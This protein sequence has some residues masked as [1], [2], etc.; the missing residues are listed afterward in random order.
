MASNS[1]IMHPLG[2]SIATVDTDTPQFLL[3]ALI[4]GHF[5]AFIHGVKLRILYM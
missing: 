3:N 2:S 5:T 4:I 1:G